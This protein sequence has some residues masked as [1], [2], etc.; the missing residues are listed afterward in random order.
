MNKVGRTQRKTRLGPTLD[1]LTDVAKEEKVPFK[2]MLSILGRSYYW[3]NESDHY[4]YELGLEYQQMFKGVNPFMDLKLTVDQAIYL[5]EK[6]EIGK[7]KYVDFKKFLGEYI[8][9]PGYEKLSERIRELVPDLKISEK[10]GV[11]ADIQDI[12]TRHLSATIEYLTPYDK[13]TIDFNLLITKWTLGYDG[14]L[15][16][17]EFQLPN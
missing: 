12:L 9:L 1:F 6:L 15:Q 4:D 7:T 17:F 10:Q 13:D 14:N 8:N 11:W 3:N 2:D 5:L 16:R